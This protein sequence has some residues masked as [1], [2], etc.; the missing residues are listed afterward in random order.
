M[1]RAVPD[2]VLCDASQ[3]LAEAACHEDVILLGYRQ[4][5]R[6]ELRRRVL[7]GVRLADAIRA[8]IRGEEPLTQGVKGL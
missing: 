1:R 2:A 7:L 5:A 4:A 8:Q 6:R 3:R